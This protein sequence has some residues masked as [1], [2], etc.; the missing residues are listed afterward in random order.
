MSD[1][2]QKQNV[3]RRDFIAAGAVTAAATTMTP[4][5]KATA[6]DEKLVGAVM[7]MSRGRSLADTFAKHS[8][9]VITV[10]YTHL[11]AHET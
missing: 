6:E 4:A 2:A 9:C 11:R 8:D 1:D 7:G 10:S 5:V 3:K